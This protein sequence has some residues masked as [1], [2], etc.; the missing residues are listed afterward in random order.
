MVLHKQAANKAWGGKKLAGETA[1]RGVRGLSV[2]KP[3]R[4]EENKGE[5]GPRVPYRTYRRED[6]GGIPRQGEPATTVFRVDA[7]EM[8]GLCFL[9]SG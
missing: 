3:L 6:H 4:A 1:G 5:S 2:G 8:G 7:R 9:Y